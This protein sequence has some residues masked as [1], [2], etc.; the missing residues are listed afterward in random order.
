MN[1]NEN[2][3]ASV[4]PSLLLNGIL[5]NMYEAPNNM[6]ERWCQ[7]YCC[8][9]DYYGNNRYDFGPGDD[10]YATLK[11]VVKMEE[12]AIKGGADALNPYTALAKFF[13]AYFFTKMSLAMGDLPMTDALQG[14]DNIT[15]AYD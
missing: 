12:E 5:Y 15:P 10:N 13:K 3:P 6:K 2:K 1:K 14:R 7:Y 9:Y 11:N 4:Q 8:N